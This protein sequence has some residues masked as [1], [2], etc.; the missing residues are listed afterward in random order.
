MKAVESNRNVKMRKLAK[1]VWHHRALYLMILPTIIFVFVFSYI[2]LYGIQLGFKDYST[3]LGIW[4]SKWVGLK[5]FKTFIEHPFFTRI[6]WNTFWINVV[7]LIFWPSSI[8]FALI[9]NEMR[10]P[11]LKKTCQ[12]LTY[13]P[14]F[15]S[16]V[17]VC[18]MCKMFLGTDGLFHIL[19][20][21]L[22]LEYVN[23]LTVPAAFAWVNSLVDVWKGLGWGTIIY[24]AAL[25]GVSPELIEAAKIDGATKLQVVWHINLPHL[26]PTVITLLI[27]RIGSMLSVGFEQVFLLQNALNL[28]ASTVI[29]TYT[30]EIGLR[31]AQ[32]SY[33]TA[34]G[35]FNNLI[36][37][38]MIVAA[39]T[40]SKKVSETS[41]W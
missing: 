27:M 18:S 22:G 21:K 23:P 15:V 33:S 39:N 8:V 28:D 13:A 7:S 6:I 41:L 9:L 26:K 32:F 10:Y 35:L 17:I 11:K 12:M 16:T 3:R 14:Y 5:H 1:S 37:V 29:S 38:I 25:S 24:L 36:N 31:G 4:G 20:T 30:Y 2:P 34:I 19:F 40:V